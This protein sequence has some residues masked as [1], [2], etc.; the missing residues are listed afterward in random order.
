MKRYLAFAFAG[1]SGFLVDAAALL[2]LTRLFG[3]DPFVA[4]A[5]S[6]GLALCLTW[7][8]NRTMTFGPSGRH[9]AEEGARYGGV[10][11]GTALVNYL[12]YSGIL[13]GWPSVPPVVALIVASGL[14]M[15]I[16]Y[17]GYSRLV[18]GRRGADA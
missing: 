6:I 18:F 16:S 2:A 7:M 15:V 9:I 17:L 13:L 5:L 11:L 8:I 1:A 12:I 4:R 3:L 10:A 14:S